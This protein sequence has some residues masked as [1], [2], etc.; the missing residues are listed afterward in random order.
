[1]P[2]RVHVGESVLHGRGVFATHAFDVGELIET[3][4][5]LVLEPDDLEHIEETAIRG[6]YFEWDDGSGGLALGLGSLYN[7]SSTPNATVEADYDDAVIRYTAIRPIATGE[8]I[9][10]DYTGGGTDDDLWFDPVDT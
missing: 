7:H 8:E 9:T 2:H 6:Y 5:V 1:M 3:C 10:I 4:P